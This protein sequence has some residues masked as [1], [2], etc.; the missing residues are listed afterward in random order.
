MS[1]SA[2]AIGFQSV[3]FPPLGLSPR[4]TLRWTF[5]QRS[6]ATS[7]TAHITDDIK[8]A[9]KELREDGRLVAFPTETVYGLG[10]NAYN[11]TAVRY[12]FQVSCAC[13]CIV[14]YAPGSGPYDQT[15][16]WTCV[17]DVRL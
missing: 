13:P 15:L 9:A 7:A 6:M 2:R 11:E 17:P 8:T 4:S 10:A 14:L 16:S 5:Q 1:L 12:V 3:P